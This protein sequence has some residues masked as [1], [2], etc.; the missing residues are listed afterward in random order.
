MIEIHVISEQGFTPRSSPIGVDVQPSRSLLTQKQDLTLA[1]H[2]L[3]Q[4][5]LLPRP[6]LHTKC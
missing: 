2:Q 6:G 3:P 1:F 4:V 5:L